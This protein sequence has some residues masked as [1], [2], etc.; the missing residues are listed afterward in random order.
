MILDLLLLQSM[1]AAITTIMAMMI[2]A[3]MTMTT[4]TTMEAAS[5]L[6]EVVQV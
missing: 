2:V 5:R 1:T 4:R 6:Q 3:T